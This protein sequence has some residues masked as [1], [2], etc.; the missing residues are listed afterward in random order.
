MLYCFNTTQ[1]NII[2]IIIIIINKNWY[3]IKYERRQ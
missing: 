1:D 3:K 2:I